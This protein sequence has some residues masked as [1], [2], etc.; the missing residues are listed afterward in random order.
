MT[1]QNKKT[2]A[3]FPGSFDP[4]TLG[5]LDIIKRACEVFD[6]VVVAIGENPDKRS[7]F[8]IHKRIEI[9]ANCISDIPNACVES[10]SGLTVDFADKIGASAIIRGLRNAH[11]F[12]YE[13]QIAVTN[14]AVSG[15][16]TFFMMTA[17]EH[18]FTSSSL[19]RQLADMGGD[20]SKLVPQI[21]I[22]ELKSL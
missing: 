20:I 11:D 16:E 14:Q 15:I 21:V 3:I 13:A 18:A 8:S 12:Q 7:L 6:Q 9:I 10:Y 4:V 17:P 5:H 2:I 22:K 19:I 1:L